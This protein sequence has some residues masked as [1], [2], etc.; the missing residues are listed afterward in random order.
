MQPVSRHSPAASMDGVP[1]DRAR[2]YIV[3]I[4][5]F[6]KDQEPKFQWPSE[7]DCPDLHT[8]FDRNSPKL[9]SYAKYPYPEGGGKTGRTNVEKALEK[10]DKYAG[11]HGGA[12]ENYPCI[13]DL[14]ASGLLIAIKTMMTIT[15]SRGGSRAYW[16][17][18]HARRLSVQELLRMQGFPATTPV[19]YVTTNQMG[20]LIGNAFTLPLY[21]RVHNA[22]VKAARELKL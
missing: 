14:C 21:V 20:G 12:V 8:L 2:I 13:V 18:Q 22:A 1:Q 11:L 10:M 4:R 15:H 17:L 7:I 19:A 5:K 9:K 6:G 3:C 16:S